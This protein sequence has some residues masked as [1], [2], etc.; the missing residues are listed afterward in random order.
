MVKIVSGYTELG[1]ATIALINL[2]NHLNSIGIDCIL[3]GSRL[4]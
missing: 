3:W 4:V 1:G 2:C